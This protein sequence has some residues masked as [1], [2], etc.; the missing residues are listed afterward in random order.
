MAD[1]GSA[2]LKLHEG[3]LG[4]VARGIGGTLV[5]PPLDLN[6]VKKYFGD[7]KAFPEIEKLMEIVGEGA[8][9]PTHDS[10]ANLIPALEYGNHRSIDDYLPQVWELS[11]IHISEPTR[12][13]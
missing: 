11:L 12:P 9:A 7:R 13:Y 2:M 1:T 6:D 10:E 8:S 4:D 3:R 5:S